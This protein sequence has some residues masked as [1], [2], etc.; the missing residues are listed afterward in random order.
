MLLAQPFIGKN[1]STYATP[2]DTDYVYL[3]DLWDTERLITK[4]SSWND[5]RALK[6]NQNEPGNLISLN[7]KGEQKYFINGLFAHARSTLIFDIGDYVEGGVDTFSAYIGVDTYAKS[8][9]N[10]V[11]FTISASKDG[12]HYTTL[13]QAGPF[14]GTS[15]AQEVI[16]SIK[17]Y[18]YLKL[19]ADEIGNNNSSDHSVYANAMLYD[20]EEFKPNLETEVDWIKPLSTYDEELKGLEPNKILESEDLELKL[21]QRTLIKRVG[22]QIMQAYATGN[23]QEKI[24]T[25]K[26]LFTNKNILKMYLTGGEPLGNYVKSFDVLSKLYHA[27]KDDLKKDNNLTDKNR[28]VFLKMMMAISLTHSGTVAL[29]ITGENNT[30]VQADPVKRYEVYRNLYL[31]ENL[32]VKYDQTFN[33]KTFESLTVEEMRWVVDARLSDEEIPWLNW[34]SSHL[35]GTKYAGR[36]PMDP[37]TY[38]WYDGSFDWRYTDPEYYKEGSKYCAPDIKNKF[39]AGYVRGEDCDEMYHIKEWGIESYTPKKPRLWAIWEEDGVCGALS[40]TGENLNN[41]YG[42]VAAV[43]RQPAHAAYLIQTKKEN[44]D[45]TFTTTWGIGN[46]VSGWALSSGTEKGERLPLNWG[47]TTNSYA[48]QYNA[49]YVILA[50]HAIDD[51]N[52]YVKSLEYTMIANIY[53]EDIAK[54]SEIY[55]KIVGNAPNLNSKNTGAIQSFNLDGWYGLIKNYL[56]DESKTSDD[57][58]HLSYELINNLHDYPLPLNDMLNLLKE[59]MNDGHR[60]VVEGSFN[61]LLTELSKVQNN[62]TEYLQGQAVRQ[63]SQYLLGKQEENIKFSFSGENA[64]KIVLATDQPFEYSL[65]YSYDASTN[66]VHGDWTQVTEGNM[67]DLRT[68]ID[69]INATNDIVVHILIDDDRSLTSNSVT[70]I[71]IEEGITPKNLYANDLENKVI[72]VTNDMEWRID[73]RV[74]AYLPY[75]NWKKFGDELP[76]LSGIKTVLVRDGAHDTYLASDYVSMTFDADPNDDPTKVYVSVDRLSATASSRQ[77]DSEHERLAIDGNINTYW[78]NLWSG[79]D[80]ARWITIEVKDEEPIVLSKIEYVPRQD[81]GTNGI[82]TKTKLEVSLDGEKWTLIDDNIIWEKNKATKTYILEVPTPAKYIR[83]TAVEAAGNFAS[84]AM[85]NIFENTTARK[86]VED[87]TVNYMTSGYI[88]DGSPKEPLVTV[89]DGDKPLIL[90]EDYLIEYT[91]NINAGTAKMSLKGMGAYKGRKNYEFTI[92][93]A[94]FPPAIPDLKV[95][96][97]KDSEELIHVLDVLPDNWFWDVDEYERVIKPGKTED[98]K[99][100]YFGEDA[101]NYKNLVMTISVT[102]ENGSLPVITMKEETSLRFD[103]E[104][105]VNISYEYFKNLLSV[106]DEEDGNN[107]ELKLD[108]S[109]T[110]WEDGKVNVEGTYHVAFQAT[111]SDGN[112]TEYVIAFTLYSSKVPIIKLD[113]KK[114]TYKV[115]EV[116]YTGSPLEPSVTVKDKNDHILTLDTDYKIVSYS[117]NTHAGTASMK[118]KG[119]GLYEGE[120]TVNFEI[121]KASMP[122]VLPEVTIAVTSTTTSLKDIPLPVGWTWHNAGIKL[123]S[124][125]NDIKVIFAGDANHHYYEMTITVIKEDIERGEF[126]PELE[127]VT[128]DTPDPVTPTNPSTPTTKTTTKVTSNTTNKPT[129]QIPGTSSSVKTSNMTT[130]TRA[131]AN[132]TSTTKEE[133]K[134]G[135]DKEDKKS[136]SKNIILYVIIGIIVIAIGATIL[137]FKNN[138]RVSS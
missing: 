51:Y 49:S 3:T 136:S 132:T 15:D 81:S 133:V 43:T 120:V 92:D 50:Q 35:E 4:T 76:D 67:A 59:R 96:I 113:K 60:L 9:G 115:E 24:E 11:N 83:L 1:I 116:T 26:W 138:K 65:N 131:S 109:K 19:Y 13:L 73:D 20:N 16:L 97:P 80:T 82:F 88:Y 44:E 102:R 112:M 90:N 21:L 56:R 25:L 129:S 128:P 124:G 71:N 110:D 94:E 23:D 135:E 61:K 30:L 122:S 111:D 12:K 107:I 75:E 125:K 119:L 89:N 47:T 103:I 98:V 46:D 130:S 54:Q 29:W 106:N 55:R 134:N 77:K 57:F 91:D 74:A 117:N 69:E 22:Y 93:K 114:F 28:E 58:Y 41:S 66:E 5:A 34:Y 14:K 68:R 85:I 7:V 118:I 126:E 105:D 31:N 64:G 45:G 86:D 36:S 53:E 2:I 79:S 8:N 32:P 27:Y 108:K 87:L 6:I 33:V 84:A 18:K 42:Q 48:S 39:V 38:I 127:G 72:G 99:I 104:K 78:H 100:V 40:K 52:N 62:S 137:I 63:V 121:L 17:D 95:T 123:K 70:V 10:G 101:D 37:Y